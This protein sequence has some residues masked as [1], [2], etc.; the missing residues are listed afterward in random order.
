MYIHVFNSSR[1][2]EYQNHNQYQAN[3]FITDSYIV[4]HILGHITSLGTKHILDSQ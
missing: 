2:T 1:Y 3:T 4:L